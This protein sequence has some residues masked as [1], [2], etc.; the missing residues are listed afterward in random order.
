MLLI[1]IMAIS[2]PP[3]AIV[4]VHGV[5]QLASNASR[6]LFALKDIRWQLFWPFL[7]G[8]ILG[9][10]A[11]SNL[12]ICFPTDFLPVPL[13]LFILL[14]T[15]LPQLKQKLW[16]PGKFFTL[17]IVQTLLTLFVGATGPLNMP[18]L[19][20]EGL[21]RDQVVV[22][23]SALMT[24]VHLIK[25]LTFGLI[26]FAFAPYLFLIAGMIIA[27]ITGSYVGTKL[28][29]HVPEKVFEKI[30]KALISLLAALM[31]IRALCF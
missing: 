21:S 13:G 14:M 25:I 9:A 2:M 19:L 20:R 3:A 7:I 31:I 16:F 6:S 11:G 8:C 1:S 10:F 24:V 22:T 30:F 18:F 12:L 5:T 27:V 28:R 4:P 26:G 29:A 15:W 23:G 17:G